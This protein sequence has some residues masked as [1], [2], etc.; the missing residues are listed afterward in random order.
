MPEQWLETSG[1]KAILGC[2]FVLA[3][4]G[5]PAAAQQYTVL[6]NFTGEADGKYPE[7]GVIS[8]PAGNLYGT[9][10][11]GGTSNR[12]VV[13]KIDAAGTETVLYSF[14]E[15]WT[16]RGRMQFWFGTPKAISTA[17]QQRAA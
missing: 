15:V 13:F 11:E 2:V 7:A 9:T 14:A 12:G 8:D 5:P 16:G 10:Y 3:L 6:H 4:M 1:A 17:L